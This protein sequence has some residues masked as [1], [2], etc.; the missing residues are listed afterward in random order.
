M[1]NNYEKEMIKAFV[2]KANNKFFTRRKDNDKK[3]QWF[4]NAFEKLNDNGK[5]KVRWIWNFGTFNASGWGLFPFIFIGGTFYY[6]Y[7]KAYLATLIC[8]ILFLV[9]LFIAMTGLHVK[10]TSMMYLVVGIPFAIINSGLS[11]YFVYRK[12]LKLK[13]KIESTC[14]SSEDR[15]KTMQIK[16]GHNNLAIWIPIIFLL[17]AIAPMIYESFMLRFGKTH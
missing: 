8:F 15:I 6:L 13:Q 2:G 7:R 3:V 11:T 16:G 1:D 9:W 5:P 10:I 17:I 14:T 12:Y 4:T